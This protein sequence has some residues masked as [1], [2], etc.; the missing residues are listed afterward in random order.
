L[1]TKSRVSFGGCT[2]ELQTNSERTAGIIDF[3]FNLIPQAEENQA[4]VH[5][6]LEENPDGELVLHR[7]GEL[8]LDGSDAGFLAEFLLGDVCHELIVECKGGMVFHAAALTWGGRGI[9]MPGGI[10]SGKSTLTVWL[11]GHG[12]N[13]LSDEL[14]YVPHG[15]ELL[16]AFPRPLHLKRPSRKVLHSLLDL[17]EERVGVM[18]SSI[19]DLVAPALLKKDNIFNEPQLAAII[20]PRYDQDKDFEWQPLSSAQGGMMLMEC[21]VNARNLPEHGFFEAA[22]LAR[23]A[24]ATCATYSHFGQIEKKIKSVLEKSPPA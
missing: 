15:T 13:Y 4:R 22:R 20:F 23:L 8:L 18:S 21:L 11:V 17:D 6:L 7:D 24:P 2:V 5:Y 3:L 14:V 9:L 19:S 10:G 1:Q 16:K 12:F